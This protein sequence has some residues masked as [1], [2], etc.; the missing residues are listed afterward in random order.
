MAA[1][2]PSPSMIFQR[3]KQGRIYSCWLRSLTSGVAHVYTILVVIK[4]LGLFPRFDAK[5]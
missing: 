5:R 4:N 3:V 1:R 2:D